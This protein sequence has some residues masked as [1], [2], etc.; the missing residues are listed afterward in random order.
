MDTIFLMLLFCYYLQNQITVLHNQLKQLESAQLS[1]KN[2]KHRVQETL[3]DVTSSSTE[4]GKRVKKHKCPLVIPAGDI[5][6]STGEVISISDGQPSTDDTDVTIFKISPYVL[7]KQ[8]FFKQKLKDMDRAYNI[9]TK[10]G[11][12]YLSVGEAKV[13]GL[14]MCGICK[15]VIEK[16]TT[17]PCQHEFCHDCILTWSKSLQGPV[18]TCPECRQGF[19]VHQITVVTKNLLIGLIDCLNWKCEYSGCGRTM[20]VANRDRHRQVCPFFSGKWHHD[21]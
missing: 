8:K 20:P 2:D 21:Y 10:K 7:N 18:K 14:M 12:Q 4:K 13:L 5:D 19:N 9:E 16:P 3:L 6:P 17:I 11:N 1:P 15:A